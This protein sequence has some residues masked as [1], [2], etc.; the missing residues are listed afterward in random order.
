MY[1]MLHFY[2]SVSQRREAFVLVQIQVHE[3]YKI[4]SVPIIDLANIVYCF[5]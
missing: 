3:R 4:C 2:H 1:I 5:M